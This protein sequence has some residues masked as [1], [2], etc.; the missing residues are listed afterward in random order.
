MK[1]KENLKLNADAMLG[2]RENCKDVKKSGIVMNHTSI[3]YNIVYI[4]LIQLHLFFST[5]NIIYIVHCEWSD[6]VEGECSEECGG[7]MKINKRTVR[8]LQRTC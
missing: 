8:V 3:I 6:L 2:T 4:S 5:S 7:G 1:T